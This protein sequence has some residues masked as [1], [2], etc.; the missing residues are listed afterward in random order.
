[1]VRAITYFSFISA[2]IHGCFQDLVC[3]QKSF[4]GQIIIKI[5]LNDDSRNSYGL[6]RW[7]K[8]PEDAVL[9][10]DVGSA[11]KGGDMPK[12]EGNMCGWGKAL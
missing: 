10:E 5:W 4:D 9:R 11:K 12:E 3:L 8:I 1:M 6:Q 7:G 2:S